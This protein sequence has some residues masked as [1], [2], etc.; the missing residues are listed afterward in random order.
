MYTYFE[1]G[2]FK[3][4]FKED[5]YWLKDENLPGYL[6]NYELHREKEGEE[7]RKWKI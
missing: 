7:Q 3:A 2:E 6:E 1:N 4:E 5:R